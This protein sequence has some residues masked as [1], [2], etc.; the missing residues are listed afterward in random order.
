MF[1]KHLE[2]SSVVALISEETSEDGQSHKLLLRINDMRR[3]SKMVVT[4]L[5]ATE[6]ADE[7]SFGV[8][9]RK[10]Y[11]LNE[12]KT[13]TFCWVVFFWGEIA[14]AVEVCAPLLRLWAL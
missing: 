3:W 11:Y 6:E 2:H 1:A 12:E 5:K 4:L 7:P 9:I 10:E 13:P 14:D 8:S